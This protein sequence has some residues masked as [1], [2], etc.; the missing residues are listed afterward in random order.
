[1]EPE[2]VVHVLRR[3]RDA[4]V[5]G[6]LMLDL[7]VIRPQ[8]VV[9]VDGA[10]AC[11]ID[12]SALLATAESAA[13]E[14]DAMVASGLFVEEARDDHDVRKHY[15]SGAELVEDFEDS[16]RD[17]PAEWIPRLRELEQ[18]CAVRERCQT[19][20]LRKPS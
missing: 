8:P 14:I 10:D 15:D 12:G 5:P 1:M 11:E 20:R 3:F 4:L 19:R 9:E 17:L 13:G 7:Q 16:P 6:G 2:D 18:A